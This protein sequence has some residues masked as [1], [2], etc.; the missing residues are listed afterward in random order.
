MTMIVNN[1][2]GSDIFIA[3]HHIKILTEITHPL[4]ILIK[5]IMVGNENGSYQ[6]RSKS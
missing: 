1:M 3:Y 2:N 4:I 6:K 5:Y